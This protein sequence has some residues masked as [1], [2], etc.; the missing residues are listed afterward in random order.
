MKMLFDEANRLVATDYFGSES[1]L[2]GVPCCAVRDGVWHLLLPGGHQ[3][4]PPLKQAL[5]MPVSASSEREGWRWKLWIS[6]S[7]TVALPVSCFVWPP[8]DLPEPGTACRK[9]LCIYGH[10]LPGMPRVTYGFG[11][12]DSERPEVLHQAQLLVQ[13]ARPG[14]HARPLR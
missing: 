9:T 11:L 3:T 5:V 12:L 13:R 4:F 1:Y 10:W 8:P 6:S 2:A 7:W 14:Q